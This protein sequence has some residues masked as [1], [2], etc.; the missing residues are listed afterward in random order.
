MLDGRV[1][2]GVATLSLSFKRTGAGN[3][4]CRRP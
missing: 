1:M 3:R 2:M 4:T